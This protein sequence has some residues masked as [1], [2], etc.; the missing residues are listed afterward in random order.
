MP[1]KSAL[2]IYSISCTHPWINC[3]APARRLQ[4]TAVCW[5]FLQYLGQRVSEWNRY[6]TS[7]L[8]S[9]HAFFRGFSSWSLCTFI[10]SIFFVFNSTS[11]LAGG[12]SPACPCDFGIGGWCRRVPCSNIF[13]CFF[14]VSL[15]W[16]NIFCGV[17]V[18]SIRVSWI[19]FSSHRWKRRP[20]VML[21]C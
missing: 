9:K 14:P 13:C 15:M 12:R 5:T 18:L 17:S 1:Y 6:Q 21:D 11:R 19:Y 4:G 20:R 10:V 16:Q 7:L 8:G 2:R 3:P